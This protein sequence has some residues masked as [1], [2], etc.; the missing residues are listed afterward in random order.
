MFVEV[1][2]S[3]FPI[4]NRRRS[5]DSVHRDLPESAGLAVKLAVNP[6]FWNRRNRQSNAAP[7]FALFAAK[8]LQRSC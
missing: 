4:R 2:Q 7:F 5:V 1:R 8:W 3:P 6:N